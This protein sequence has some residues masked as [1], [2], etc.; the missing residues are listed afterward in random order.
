MNIIM[1][2]ENRFCFTSWKKPTIN[3]NLVSYLIWQKERCPTT[4]L[5]HYQGYIEFYKFYTFGQAKQ[6]FRDKTI[7]IEV[8]KED[9]KVN[10]LYCTKN[11]SFANERYEFGEGLDTGIEFSWE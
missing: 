8:A 11:E 7:H 9:K 3:E 4:Q 1:E 5:E 6:C 2:K 10:Y